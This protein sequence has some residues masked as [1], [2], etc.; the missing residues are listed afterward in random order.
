MISF[1]DCSILILLT[2]SVLPNAVVTKEA[3]AKTILAIWKSW[4]ENRLDTGWFLTLFPWVVT[5]HTG[6]G[7]RMYDKKTTYVHLR[8]WVPF[9]LKLV[10][11][12]NSKWLYVNEENTNLLNLIV[13]CLA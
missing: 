3:A 6:A 10:E 9:L 4:H 2:T 7:R 11:K 8:C 5:N 12:S 13:V 1:M